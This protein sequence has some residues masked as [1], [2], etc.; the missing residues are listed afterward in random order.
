MAEPTQRAPWLPPRWFI[1]TFWAGHR[2]FYRVSPGQLGLW[3]PKGTSYGTLRL[4]TVGRRSGRERSV[5]LGYITDGEALC[6]MA[7]NGWGAAEPAWWLNLQAQPEASVQTAD[8]PLRVRGRAATGAERAR[9]WER[10]REVDGGL[11]GYAARRPN[12]TAVVL[13]EPIPPADKTGP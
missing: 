8:G 10:W 12:E 2:A 1:R 5:I 11:D 9:L 4:T 7:M 6:T 3:R 13:L